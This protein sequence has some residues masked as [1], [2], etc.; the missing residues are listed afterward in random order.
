MLVGC[1]PFDDP[2]NYLPLAGSLAR[3]EGLAWNGRPTAYRPPL[4]PMLLAPLVK[5]GGER[6]IL[7]IALLHLALGA[8]TVAP[9]GGRGPAV[10]AERPARRWPPRSSWPATPCS[11]GKAGS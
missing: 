10:G 8:A 7:G 6:P 4:Y 5:L 9:D 2:D 1:G 11:S 3:G